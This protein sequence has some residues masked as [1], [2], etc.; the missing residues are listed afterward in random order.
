MYR[1]N[2]LLNISTAVVVYDKTIIEG[3]PDTKKNKQTNNKGVKQL[4]L[5]MNVTRHKIRK[6]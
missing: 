6:Q 5:P 4:L 1:S 2:D 3:L